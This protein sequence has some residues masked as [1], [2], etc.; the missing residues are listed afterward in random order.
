MRCGQARN[1]SSLYLDGRLDVRR[2]GRLER[3]LVTCAE[4]R[5]DLA[6]LR[7]TQIALR[8]ESLVEE[9]TGLHE[10]VMRRVSAYEARR[11][12]EAAAERQRLAARRVERQERRAQ[13]WRG[14]GL[15]RALALAV[16][17]TALV[18]FA[19]VT[20]P[21]LL[22]DVTGRLGP[23]VLQLL[24]TPGPEQIAWSVWIAGAALALGACA[25]FARA[26]ASEELRRALAE[27]LPQLW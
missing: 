8:E 1:W 22:S 23:N 4:C 21:H 2:L 14:I 15:R 7:V 11:A 27:R 16:A 5:R 13:F 19:Q 25:W 6:R 26:D 20:T 9:P 24:F 3:H 10:A 17:F 18:I 12:S